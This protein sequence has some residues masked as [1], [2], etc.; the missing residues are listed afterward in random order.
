MILTTDPVRMLTVTEESKSAPPH[1]SKT[2]LFD[3]INEAHSA[4]P[5]Q[6]MHLVVRDF[7]ATM[8]EQLS[9]LAEDIVEVIS[10]EDKYWLL[11]RE[12]KSGQSGYIP[13]EIIQSMEEQEAHMNRIRNMTITQP[14]TPEEASMTADDPTSLEHSGFFKKNRPHEKI[15]SFSQKSP[16]TLTF[17]VELP[18]TSSSTSSLASSSEQE[19][20][21][22]PPSLL[23]RAYERSKAR[24]SSIHPKQPEI[25]QLLEQFL[26]ETTND[27]LKD[28]AIPSPTKNKNFLTRLFKNDADDGGE[29]AGSENKIVQMVR[30]YSGNVLEAPCYKTCMAF[31]GDTLSNL[32]RHAADKFNLLEDGHDY[33]LSVVHHK[34]FGKTID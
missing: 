4:I 6:R 21:S 31:E 33:I 28:E 20:S 18:R 23:K 3:G 16:E 30:I 25:D 34:T 19:S 9:V 15:V 17:E 8:D 7:Y 13:G 5:I 32:A 24:D 11:V 12:T 14:T 22:P 26:N 29:A 10:D 27:K 1:P 2:T